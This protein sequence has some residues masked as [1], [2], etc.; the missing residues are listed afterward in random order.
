MVASMVMYVIFAVSGVLGS[1]IAVDDLKQL[2][3]KRTGDSR[4]LQEEKSEDHS[5][6]CK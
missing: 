5:T 6:T 4:R 2:L 3:S 1:A